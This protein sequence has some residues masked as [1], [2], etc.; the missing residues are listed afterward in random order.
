MSIL[1]DQPI[2]TK[3]ICVPSTYQYLRFNKQSSWSKG[4][5]QKLSERAVFHIKVRYIF[6]HFFFHVPARATR[7]FHPPDKS[8]TRETW[9]SGENCR[10]ESIITALASA[11]SAPIICN[12]ALERAKESEKNKYLH[13]WCVALYH[14]SRSSLTKLHRVPLDQL[15][16][17]LNHFS[18]PISFAFRPTIGLRQTTMYHRL[19]R[20]FSKA[21]FLS[22]ST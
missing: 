11:L 16:T 7:I 8:H 1:N 15:P 5:H 12:R 22:P 10:P 17:L 4:R 20:A 9:R 2:D 19:D 18:L 3:C 21:P 14:D 6:T 13:S